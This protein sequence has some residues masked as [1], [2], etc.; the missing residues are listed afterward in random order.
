MTFNLFDSRT[1]LIILPE[2]LLL[3]L[4]GLLLLL[5]I[6]WPE[7]RKRAL[8]LLAAA[9]IAVAGLSALL[10]VRPDDALVF[11][12]ML[13]NDMLA[14]VFRLLF[15]FAG[16]IVA[17]LSVDSPGV[18]RKGDQQVNVALDFRGNVVQE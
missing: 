6:V 17:L 15:I 10:F 11:G 5:D 4:A 2:I 16:A 12:G 1:L 18:A 14:Y 3:L 9:G 13:R 7:S 8:G